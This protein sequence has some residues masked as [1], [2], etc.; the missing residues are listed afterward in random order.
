MSR[1]AHAEAILRAAITAAEPAA[2]VRR[3]LDSAIELQDDATVR[4]LAIGKAAPAM[5]EPVFGLFGERITDSLI[6]TPAGTHSTRPALFG[7]HPLPDESSVE[8]G[9]A[10]HDMLAAARSGETVL[11]LLSGGASATA[12][13]PLGGVT[14]TEYADCVRRLLHAGAPIG[15]VN[16]VRRHLDALKGGGMALLAAPAHVLGLVLSDVVGDPLEIIASGPLSPD[17]TTA[18]DALRVL[19]QHGVLDDC[20]PSIRALLDDAARTRT[21]REVDEDAFRNVRVRIIGGNDVAVTG[22]ASAADALGYRV[23]RATEPVTGLAREAGASLA[24]EALA[25]QVKE[26]LPICIVA[27]GETTVAVQGSG[28]GGRNQEIVLAACVALDAARGI[29]VGSIGTDGIDGPTDAAGA[30]ADESTLERAAAHGVDPHLAL[31]Q[32]DSYTFFDATGDLIRTGPTG[33]NVN[34]VHV[35]LIVGLDR[36]ADTA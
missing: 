9:R 15:D 27:G 4:V 31:Q 23:R 14:V 32:N 33:T 18:D 3:A 6:V 30:I 21:T 12:V 7:A 5:V 20:A 26:A 16:T 2:L 8:A 34:D 1:R 36:A 24:T 28:R 13:Q 22:A 11:V 19:R 29:T 35:A 17:P 25:L 10:V